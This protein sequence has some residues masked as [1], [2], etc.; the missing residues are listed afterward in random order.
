[1]EKKHIFDNPN[2]V[3][4][5]LKIFFSSVIVLL[6]LDVIY[7]FLSKMHII[8]AHVIYRWEEW[9]GFYAFYGFVACVILV[10]VSKYILRPLVK[11]K[12]DYYDN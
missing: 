5:L 9:W 1:M 3:K 8:H 6:I 10:L 12:E 4:K 11:R 7:L 2:N